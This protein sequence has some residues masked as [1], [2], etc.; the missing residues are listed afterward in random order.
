ME[1]DKY[2]RNAVVD[3]VVDGDTIDVNVS[4]GFTVWVKQR[5]RLARIDTPEIRGSEKVEGKKSKDYVVRLLRPGTLLIIQTTKTG[6]YGRYIAEVWYG[7]VQVIE[8]GEIETVP[9]GNA[10]LLSE[11]DWHN[12]NDELLEKGLAKPYKGK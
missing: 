10:A 1:K 11:C 7:T 2:F 9:I 12:L 4:L 3:R 5:L 6:K 8:K